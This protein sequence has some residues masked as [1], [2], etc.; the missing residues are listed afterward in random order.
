MRR[1]SAARRASAAALF[2]RLTPSQ[3]EQLLELLT[4]LAGQH[5]ASPARGGTGR[6]QE[7]D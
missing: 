7:L 5:S 6:A 3:G 4:L 2:A 1:V